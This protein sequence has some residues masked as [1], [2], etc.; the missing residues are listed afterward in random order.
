MDDKSP[1]LS[2]EG[3]WNTEGE[4]AGAVER[5]QEAKSRRGHGGGF[6]RDTKVGCNEIEK[7]DIDKGEAFRE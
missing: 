3:G 5:N 6:R 7:V 2:Y 1:S 4:V